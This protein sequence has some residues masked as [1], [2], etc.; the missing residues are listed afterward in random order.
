[1]RDMQINEPKQNVEID[2][3][4]YVILGKDTKVIQ[5]K[6]G[7]LFQQMVLEEMDIHKQINLNPYLTW[8]IKI[9]MK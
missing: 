2:I 5:W 1:M 4:I 3:C 7:K 6:Q 8:Y 9:N